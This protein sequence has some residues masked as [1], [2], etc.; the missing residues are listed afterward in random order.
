MSGAKEFSSISTA[1][2]AAFGKLKILG[3]EQYRLAPLIDSLMQIAFSESDANTRSNLRPE[4]KLQLR[5]Q[6][7][8]AP[9]FGVSKNLHAFRRSSINTTRSE[10]S[11]I[12]TRCQDL[13]ARLRNPKGSTTRARTQ[14]AAAIKSM[15]QTTILALA[16]APSLTIG[17]A[18]AHLDIAFVRLTL[19]RS[20]KNGLINDA[21][22]ADVVDVLGRFAVAAVPSDTQD[23]GRSRDM[24]AHVAGRILAKAYMTLTGKP[25]TII[26]D[27]ASV[28]E[29]RVSYAGSARLR[30]R[31]EGNRASGPRSQYL[32]LVAEV[33]LAMGIKTDPLHVAR[34]A[35]AAIEA[36]DGK[37]G[38]RC[39]TSMNGKAPPILS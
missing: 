36:M 26:V 34:Q 31:N 28:A 27:P 8:S 23:E 32:D 4:T 18:P 20:L 21:R 3:D 9:A 14:L 1:L 25:P 19:P 15:H 13:A 39:S 2:Q 11:N 12:A 6:A 22:L 17:H 38:A 37:K 33:L 10:L 7:R 16:D 35:K 5:S 30:R 24:R 29:R